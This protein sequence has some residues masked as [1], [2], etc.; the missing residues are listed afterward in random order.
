MTTLYNVENTKI[1][2]TD[3]EAQALDFAIK[4]CMRYGFKNNFYL[5]CVVIE[6]EGEDYRYLYA[7]VA[8]DDM[9]KDVKLTWGTLGFLKLN[10]NR[11]A[12]MESSAVV[13]EDSNVSCR[14]SLKL[15]NNVYI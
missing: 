2:F 4:Y 13:I 7:V 14:E 8:S 5:T 11:K 10:S 1:I 3:N 12:C 6:N 15:N 9:P